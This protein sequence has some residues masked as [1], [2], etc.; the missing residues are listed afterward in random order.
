MTLEKLIGAILWQDL[1]DQL[2]HLDFAVMI[3]Q[4]CGTF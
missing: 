4:S 3:M 1:K 2:A